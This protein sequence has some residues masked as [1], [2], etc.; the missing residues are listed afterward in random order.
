MT[1]PI[2]AI[3]GVPSACQ[4]LPALVTGGQP[5]LAHL[6]ALAAA[7]TTVILD[8][9]APNEPRPCNEAEGVARLGMRYVNIPVVSNGVLDDALMDRLLAAFRAHAAESTFCHCAG[10][11]RVGGAL[12]PHLMLDLGFEEE[13][14]IE[15]ARRVGLS[16]P[17]LLR[18]A[19]DY[20]RRHRGK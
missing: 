11:N 7:G 1:T 17:Q 20:V 19:L 6:E 3:R 16:S 5:Q 8:L 15:A 14:A 12:I 10:G 18:W 13:D 2:D 9:R 4:A